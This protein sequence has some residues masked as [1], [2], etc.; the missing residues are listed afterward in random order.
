MQ[1]L[2]ERAGVFTDCRFQLRPD[3]KN[4]SFRTTV[5]FTSSNEHAWLTEST[6]LGW[7]L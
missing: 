6:Y 7:F 3:I 4:V 5:D 2:I 1:N